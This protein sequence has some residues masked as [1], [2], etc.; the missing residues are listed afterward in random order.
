[1]L[2]HNSSTLN[3]V[4]FNWWFKI[5]K[6]VSFFKDKMYHTSVN[7]S[8]AALNAFTGFGL[9]T[10]CTLVTQSLEYENKLTLGTGKKLTKRQ[11]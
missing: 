2:I 7:F 4:N 9:T 5:L 6:K 11:K 8:R 3:N 10:Y 1:M